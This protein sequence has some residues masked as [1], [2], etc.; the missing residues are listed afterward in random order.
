[1]SKNISLCLIMLLATASCNKKSLASI[2][3]VVTIVEDSNKF[4]CVKECNRFLDNTENVKLVF[5]QACKAATFDNLTLHE[6]KFTEDMYMYFVEDRYGYVILYTNRSQ[7]CCRVEFHCENDS[8]DFL[9]F[10]SA[11][12]LPIYM[13]VNEEEDLYITLSEILGS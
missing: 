11:F 8:Y 4:I 10:M 6:E 7:N 5:M 12:M 3:P 9:E 1:M 13:T 2:S